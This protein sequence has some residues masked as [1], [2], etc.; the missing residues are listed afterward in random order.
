MAIPYQRPKPPKTNYTIDSQNQL[1]FKNQP[2]ISLENFYEKIV[3]VLVDCLPEDQTKKKLIAKVQQ[4]YRIRI[5][6]FSVE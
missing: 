2:M 5:P 3:A 1:C 6:Q 4:V